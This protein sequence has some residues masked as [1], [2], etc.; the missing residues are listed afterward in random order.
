MGG[1][2]RPAPL[3]PTLAPSR[4]SP[5]L[6]ILGPV[7]VVPFR[8]RDDDGVR[9]DDGGD[10]GGE[11]GGERFR[12]GEVG[13]HDLQRRAR[14]LGQPPQQRRRFGRVA[15]HGAHGA[16]GGQEPRHDALADA[17]RRASDHHDAGRGRVA[18]PAAAR[19][20]AQQ[21]AQHASGRVEPG[22]LLQE[23]AW[24]PAP[25]GWRRG[26]V[27]ARVGAHPLSNS[28]PCVHFTPS[29]P[30]LGAGRRRRTQRGRRH[31]GAAR[32]LGRGGIGAASTRASTPSLAFRF[33]ARPRAPGAHARGR[34]GQRA[35][36][37]PSHT[38]LPPCDADA[39]RAPD[40]VRS[41]EG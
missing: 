12:L 28:V 18:A 36:P 33:A 35:C 17:A 31:A 9:G 39:R 41:I 20:R 19:Q 32:G 2:G 3:G 27:G 1:R 23:A 24:R 14:R 8:R 25:A 10:A 38:P 37:S 5:H 26:C 22:E 11:G 4:S 29:L 16:A 15:H 30:H 21:A 6:V 34:A 13:R 40:G 7:H